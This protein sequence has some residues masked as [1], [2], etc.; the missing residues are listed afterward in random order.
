[1][2][3][4][5]E[6]NFY[7]NVMVL[8]YAPMNVLRKMFNI[9]VLEKEASSQGRGVTYNIFDLRSRARSSSPFGSSTFHEPRLTF[10]RREVEASN[11]GIASTR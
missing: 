5:L 9:D 1:M 6:I 8:R 7:S 4:L 10:G 3:K 11:R 2:Q